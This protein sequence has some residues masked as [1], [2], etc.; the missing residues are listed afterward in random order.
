LFLFATG[1]LSQPR[2]ETT[3]SSVSGTDDS[4]S[5]VKSLFELVARR[6]APRVS[7]PMP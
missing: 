5:S 1:V 6:V 3:P 4:C 2:K 7:A